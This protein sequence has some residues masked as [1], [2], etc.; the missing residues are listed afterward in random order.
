MKLVLAGLTV[1]GFCS[2]ANAANFDEQKI[3]DDLGT[4]LAAEEICN[5]GYDQTAIQKYI[6]DVVPA[7]VT[8][9]PGTLGLWTRTRK[10]QMR[11]MTGSE[12]TAQ[13]TSVANIAKNLGFIK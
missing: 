11:E 12:K 2:L 13:C 7:D 10:S 3:A 5:L 6:S 4:V 1:V 9:F 8:S